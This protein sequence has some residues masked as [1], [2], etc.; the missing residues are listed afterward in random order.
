MTIVIALI[1]LALLWSLIKCCCCAGFS[2]KNT[3]KKAH[4]TPGFFGGFAGANPH[5]AAPQPYMAPPGQA[6][7]YS[8]PYGNPGLAPP[9]APTPQNGISDQEYARRLQ[10]FE[11]SQAAQY[12]PAF[13]A[14]RPASAL[15]APSHIPGQPD[16][17]NSFGA[18]TPNYSQ[19]NYPQPDRP[20]SAVVGTHAPPAMGEWRQPN[21]GSNENWTPNR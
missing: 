21:S 1:I 12:N 18:F 16:R 11:N 5:P 15:E 13:A 4:P 17:P 8:A 7:P 14:G 20:H 3:H 19:P 6:P 10:L 2:R 9:Y